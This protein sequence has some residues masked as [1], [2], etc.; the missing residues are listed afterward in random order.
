VS[1]VDCF[2]LHISAEMADRR[3]ING[4]VGGTVAPV[5]ATED[6]EEQKFA[7]QHRERASNAIRKICLYIFLHLTFPE[8]TY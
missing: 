6:V 4:P 3:R 5:F 2:W 1:Q 7:V 8:V